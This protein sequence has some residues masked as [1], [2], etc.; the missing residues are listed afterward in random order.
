[1]PPPLVIGHKGDSAHAP[2]NTLAAVRLALAEG[3]DGIE[4]DLR[5]TRDGV[6]VLLHDAEV[7][8]TTSGTGAVA[9]LSLEQ[10]A[11]LDASFGMDAFRGE[12]VPTLGQLLD[13]V[14]GRCLLVLEYKSLD[15]VA[16]SVPLIRERDALSWCI[17]WSF[18]AEIL[19][20]LRDLLPGLRRTLLLGSDEAWTERLAAATGLGCVA[21]SLRH[22]YVT[23][24][25][26][27]AARERGL[28]TYA[29]T[30]NEAEDWRRLVAAGAEGIVTDDPGRLRRFLSEAAG[31]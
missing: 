2:E 4:V 16:P 22:E 18:R 23:A 24:A 3:A 9:F 8:R 31:A 21:I 12:R 13:T 7:D 15:A 30:A 10:V 27:A 5:A 14:A 29:W 20:S 11:G 17:A 25:R 6:P 19:E 1:V 28:L 26:V